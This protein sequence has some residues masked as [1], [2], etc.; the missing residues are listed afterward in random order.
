MMGRHSG[1]ARLGCR[2]RGRNQCK[3]WWNDT[4]RDRL[5]AVMHWL[6]AETDSIRLDV[7]DEGPI[8]IS[9]VPIEFDSSVSYVVPQKVAGKTV[10]TQEAD[11]N[12]DDDEHDDELLD[13]ED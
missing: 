10:D 7:G 5:L 2:R 3:N 1:R 11:P 9:A 13:D 12:Y 8:M 4:W 6:A